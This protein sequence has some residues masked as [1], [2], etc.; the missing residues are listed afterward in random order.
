M[1]GTKVAQRQIG[2]I[3][4]PKTGMWESPSMRMSSMP[5]RY[6]RP[7]GKNKT[8]LIAININNSRYFICK[9]IKFYTCGRSATTPN[10]P[11]LGPILMHHSCYYPRTQRWHP[12]FHNSWFRHMPW[13]YNEM[14]QP[15][16]PN[17][18]HTTRP[19]Y[20]TKAIYIFTHSNYYLELLLVEWINDN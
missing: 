7:R 10:W 4:G 12:F 9:S 20:D 5:G 14:I 2:A 6:C 1:G 17:F 18:I 13:V 15:F 8:P 16:D 11:F 3:L 19:Q